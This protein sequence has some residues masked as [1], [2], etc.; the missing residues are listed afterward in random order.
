MPLETIFFNGGKLRRR[1]NIDLK[2]SSNFFA[3]ETLIFGRKAMGEIVESGELDDALQIYKN[4]KLLYSD[5]NKIKGNIDKKI[6]KSLVSKGNN[7][8]CNIVYTG[9]KIRIYEKQILKYAN[10]SKY[11]FGTSIVNGV[12]LLKILAKNINDIRDFLSDL[13]KI[14]GKNFNLPRIWSF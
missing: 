6:L 11:F 9:K 8:F 7:I 10:K 1:L 14:L 4:N 12:L 13:V 2:T 3:V 5:F